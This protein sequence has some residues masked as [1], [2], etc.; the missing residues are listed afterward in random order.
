MIAAAFTH[1]LLTAYCNNTRGKQVQRLS[2]ERGSGLGASAALGEDGGDN[3]DAGQH[4][5]AGFGNGIDAEDFVQVTD[6]QNPQQGQ[7][8]AATPAHRGWLPP[9]TTMAMAM[10]S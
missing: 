10:S 7:A 4:Q 3:D 5:P 1:V 2:K 6:G 9:M 8:D